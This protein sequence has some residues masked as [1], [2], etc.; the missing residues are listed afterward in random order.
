[1][2]TY[3]INQFFQ[4]LNTAIYFEKGIV[5]NLL[6]IYFMFWGLED[7]FT[8]RIL[9]KSQLFSKDIQGLHWKFASFEC[10]GME[11]VPIH[12]M[13]LIPVW[14]WLTRHVWPRACSSLIKF[15]CGSKRVLYL[16]PNL[17]CA[18]VDGQ[19]P[20]PEFEG[21]CTNIDGIWSSS[22]PLRPIQVVSF[23]EGDEVVEGPTHLNPK[24]ASV[25]T[26]AVASF[27]DDWH[28]FLLQ[29]CSNEWKS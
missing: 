5:K 17:S 29:W 4:A 18:V 2:M 19:W 9:L 26:C 3:Q 22:F 25:A 20:P 27:F 28:A 21:Q 12:F 8:V 23:V 11:S 14:L 10:C 7:C 16:A 13:D 24:E 1:M 15:L 6:F